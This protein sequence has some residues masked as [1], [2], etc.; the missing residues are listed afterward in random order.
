MEPPK[1]N[2]KDVERSNSAAIVAEI[3]NIWVYPIRIGPQVMLFW[4]INIDNKN[5]NIWNS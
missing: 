5:L 2:D 3:S 4:N 1:E